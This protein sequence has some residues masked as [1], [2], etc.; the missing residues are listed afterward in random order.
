MSDN[1][2]TTLPPGWFRIGP[3]RETAAEFQGPMLTAGTFEHAQEIA[4]DHAVEVLGITWTQLATITGALSTEKVKTTELPDGWEWNADGYAVGR[5]S[6]EPI[7]LGVD[8]DGDLH[9]IESDDNYTFAPIP[10]VIEVLRRA[11]AIPDVERLTK[12]LDDVTGNRDA[13]ALYSRELA[14]I[15]GC[16]PSYADVT[17]TV[18]RRIQ[19]RDEANE[20]AADQEAQANS[21]H[22]KRERLRVEC[23]RIT[24][25]RDTARAEL[26]IANDEI[27][28]LERK[29]GR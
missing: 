19:E 10:M 14:E 4:A 9:T 12:E 29:V 7:S 3:D 6:G 24:Q 16:S 25:E 2:E 1:R 18:K 11:G 26:R 23:E 15:L 20:R 17:Q 27:L 5:H 13:L 22:R 28:R 21:Y 8:P